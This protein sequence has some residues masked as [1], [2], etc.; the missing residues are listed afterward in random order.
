MVKVRLCNNSNNW[1][2]IYMYLLDIIKLK[3]SW[4]VIT[5]K[6]IYYKNVWFLITCI[7]VHV[8]WR[9]N[10]YSIKWSLFT[11]KYIVQLNIRIGNILSILFQDNNFYISETLRT[12]QHVIPVLVSTDFDNEFSSAVILGWSINFL[13]CYF[14]S[15]K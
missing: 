13:C 12:I 7:S 3:K 1:W 4:V 5:R 6:P 15:S 11:V 14:F 8:I 10:I 9:W 2:V